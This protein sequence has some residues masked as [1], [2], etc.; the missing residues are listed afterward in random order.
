MI[1]R[2]LPLVFCFFS[3]CHLNALDVHAQL[4]L[5]LQIILISHCLP[6]LRYSSPVGE[7]ETGKM[8]VRYTTCFNVTAWEMHLSSQQW[9][10]RSDFI[11]SK[12]EWFCK[13]REIKVMFLTSVQSISFRSGQQELVKNESCI[14]DNN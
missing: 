14:H 7:E 1:K 5:W 11:N 8:T 4:T 6:P 13:R 9:I 3:N 2:F 12:V 10:S